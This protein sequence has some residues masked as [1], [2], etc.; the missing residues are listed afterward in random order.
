M[1]FLTNGYASVLSIALIGVAFGL[2]TRDA[3]SNTKQASETPGGRFI[4]EHVRSEGLGPEPSAAS[5]SPITLEPSTEVSVADTKFELNRHSTEQTQR[6]NVASEVEM[7]PG[8][9]HPL[10]VAEIS[11]AADGPL[12][13]LFVAEGDPVSADTVLALIDNRVALASVIAA[14]S[15]ADR[16]AMLEAAKAKVS[17][18]EQ[19][20]NRIQ[21]AA[22]KKAASGL[23]VDEASSRLSEAKAA[24]HEGLESQRDAFARLKIEQARLE[25]YEIRTPFDGTVIKIYPHLGETVSRGAPIVKIADINRLRSDLHIPLSLVASRRVGQSLELRADLPG[26][27]LL[28]AKILFIAPLID[29]ATQTIRVVVEIENSNKQLPAGFAVRLSH[30]G[31]GSDSNIQ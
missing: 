19:F 30:T 25:T 3:N 16:Q 28:N 14:Q 20:L 10:Q 12:W 22:S 23:E 1:K 26:H 6:S 11:A 29:A 9:A 7:L 8:I 27:P 2:W 21:Q 15:S 31:A 18:A 4:S 13:K 24:L 17:L 5:H